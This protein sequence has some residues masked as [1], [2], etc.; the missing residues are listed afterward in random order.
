M[1]EQ[2][3]LTVFLGK[4]CRVVFYDE[5]KAKIFIG[6]MASFNGL[7]ATFEKVEN[8]N[9]K[10]TVAISHREINRIVLEEAI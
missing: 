6:K 4:T 10:I 2:G 8:P 3:P 9:K 5:G 7:Y 1:A